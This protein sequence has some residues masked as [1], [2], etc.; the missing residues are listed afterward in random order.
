MQ[1]TLTLNPFYYP[2]VLIEKLGI[3]IILVLSFLS[4]IG[5]FILFVWQVNSFVLANYI[6]KN[7]QKKLNEILTESKDLEIN[8]SQSN[9][10]K[11]LETLATNFNF[12]KADKIYYI[13]VLEGQVVVK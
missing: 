1:K 3:K 4:I 12:E 10:L 7:Y 6:Y 9:S 8:F 2:A 5:L 11:N 13:Q